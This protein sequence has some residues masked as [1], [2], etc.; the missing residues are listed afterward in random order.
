[1]TLN[2]GGIAKGYIIG[3]AAMTLKQNN[4]RRGIIKAGGDM[5]IFQNKVSEKP[6]T[7]GIQHPRRVVNSL[8]RLSL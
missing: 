1:M 2:L 5:A 6:M 8:A 4:V 7:I 3:K